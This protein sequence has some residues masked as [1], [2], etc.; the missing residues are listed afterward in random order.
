MILPQTN[1]IDPITYLCYITVS[2]DFVEE[3]R[4]KFSERVSG[5]KTGNGNGGFVDFNL[6]PGISRR[7]TINVF[8]NVLVVRLVVL[9]KRI[10]F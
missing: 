7:R 2:F 6:V 9:S 3:W 8:K 1:W 5:K 10:S 4:Q